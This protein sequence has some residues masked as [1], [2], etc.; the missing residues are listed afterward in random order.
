M[1]DHRPD[2][3]KAEAESLLQ[4]SPKPW[5][6]IPDAGLASAPGGFIQ[7]WSSGLTLQRSIPYLDSQI[8]NYGLPP[9]LAGLGGLSP[10]LSM[11]FW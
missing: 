1:H 3:N 7:T 4:A 2:V 5:R 11:R 10:T 8:H 9:S 6:T